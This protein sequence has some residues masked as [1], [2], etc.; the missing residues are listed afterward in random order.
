MPE[1]SFLEL[2]ERLSEI[3]LDGIFVSCRQTPQIIL[4]SL[5]VR[6]HL[7]HGAPCSFCIEHTAHVHGPLGTMS[8]L[9]Q[10]LQ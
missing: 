9:L 6:E 5:K 1:E 8:L 10:F 3:L 7:E 4:W 2:A